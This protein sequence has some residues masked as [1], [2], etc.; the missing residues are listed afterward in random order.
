MAKVRQILVISIADASQKMFVTTDDD[1]LHS[2]SGLLKAPQPS[3]RRDSFVHEKSV[4]IGQIVCARCL[5]IGVTHTDGRGVTH[6][7]DGGVTHTDF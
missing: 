7:Y 6:T 1:C 3:R 4:Q 2:V 5:S